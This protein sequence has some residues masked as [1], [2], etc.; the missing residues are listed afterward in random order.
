MPL[1]SRRD[2]GSLAGAPKEILIRAARARSAAYVFL[3]AALERC[4]KDSLGAV[5]GEIN[6]RGVVLKDL[7][8]S[9]FALLA[10]GDLE[11]MRTSG[12]RRTLERHVR[13]VGMF[14]QVLGGIGCS[15]TKDL[16]P[17]DGRT[18]RAAH[19]DTIWAVFG[20][21]RPA[22]P[23][24]THSLALSDLANGRN[25]VAHGVVDPVTFGRGK[26]TADVVRLVD[27]IEDVILHVVATSD[28]YLTSQMYKR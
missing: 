16:L 3:S 1:G 2:G 7:R 28:G 8:T 12:R 22:L 9:L 23:N 20:F 10:S 15:F 13:A 24:P 4:L 5:L 18:L 25:D 14:G 21:P 17:L 26:A 6:A 11:F 27:K 19:F